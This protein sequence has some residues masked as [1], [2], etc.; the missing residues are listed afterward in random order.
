MHIPEVLRK[1]DGNDLLASD[2][3]LEMNLACFVK[4]LWVIFAIGYR[5]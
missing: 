4:F 1:T 2:I 5:T 3:F